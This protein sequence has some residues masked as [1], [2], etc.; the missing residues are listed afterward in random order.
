[1]SKKFLIIT[2]ILAIAGIIFQ[3]LL[4]GTLSSVQSVLQSIIL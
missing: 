2:S 3:L 1:M 4:G